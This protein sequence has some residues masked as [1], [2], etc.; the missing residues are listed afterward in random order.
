MSLGLGLRLS[1]SGSGGGAAG[2]SSASLPEGFVH[3]YDFS[4][5]ANLTLSGNDITGATDLGS[6]GTDL[7]SASGKYPLK[8]GSMNGVQAA[9]FDGTNDI[10]KKTTGASS[11]FSTNNFPFTMAV[12]FK[13]DSITGNEYVMCTVQS[14]S[15]VPRYIFWLRNEGDC[16]FQ[17][18][19]GSNNS[20]TST[21]GT[22]DTNE[23]VF[24]AT[25][26]ASDIVNVW[27]DGTQ[28]VTDADH[29]HA[30]NRGMTGHISLGV[31]SY[32]FAS[33]AFFYDGKIGEAVWYDS[34]LSAGDIASLNNYLTSKWLP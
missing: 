19:D 17:T 33:E 13:A 20:Q 32:S 6:T 15:T 30:G 12:A 25:M 8:T 14:S 11:S 2:G 7:V 23:H 3:H 27:L 4:D 24:V 16:Q 21:F 5:D 1:L 34:V 10:L 31:Y 26:D 22:R 18:V 29:S 9:D 28:V